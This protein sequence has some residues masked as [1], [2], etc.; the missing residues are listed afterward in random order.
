MDKWL[1]EN[2]IATPTGI[3]VRSGY[4]QI[5]LYTFNIEKVR[6]HLYTEEK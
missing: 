4:V 2:G 5:P 3:S 1:E 6:E